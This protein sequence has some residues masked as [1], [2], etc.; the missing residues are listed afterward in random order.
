MAQ[1]YLA[2]EMFLDHFMKF[3]KTNNIIN[4]NVASSLKKLVLEIDDYVSSSSLIDQM[5]KTEI[6]DDFKQSQVSLFPIYCC[7]ICNQQQYS[8]KKILDHLKSEGHLNRKMR[9]QKLPSLRESISD[10]SEKLSK[11]S[12][13]T[14]NVV[15]TTPD[16]SAKPSAKVAPQ[17]AIVMTD[18]NILPFIPKQQESSSHRSGVSQI[19]QTKDKAV[20]KPSTSQSSLNK[21]TATTSAKSDTQ[22]IKRTN[23]QEKP[24]EKRERKPKK[25]DPSIVLKE[26]LQNNDLD[27]Y[28]NRKIEEAEMIRNS[29]DTND[30]CKIL[31]NLLS[32]QFPK[33][34]LNPFGSRVI[35]TATKSSD[36]DIFIDLGEF[37]QFSNIYL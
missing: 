33:I 10:V 9:N 3:R 22:S 26:F 11:I 7:G 4:I 30:I 23:K 17:K 24:N 34:E 31:F 35:G 5:L 15:L 2:I 12:M 6:M 36:L 16:K 18:K 21:Q 28:I 8:G 29:N 32:E 13:S 14:Q 25:K 27:V 1:F 19:L 20:L 37:S